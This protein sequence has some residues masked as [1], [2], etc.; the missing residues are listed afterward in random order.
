MLPASPST[1]A[2]RS[3]IEGVLPTDEDVTACCIDHFGAVARQFSSGMSRTDKINRVLLYCPAAEILAALSAHASDRYAQ[4]EHLLIAQRRADANPYRGI[5]PFHAEH[6]SLF[7]GRAALTEK[8][9]RRFRALL[10][11]TDALRILAVLGPSGSGKSSVTLA[12]LVPMLQ[13][14]AITGSI[15]PR[16]GILTPSNRPLEQLARILMQFVDTARAGLSASRQVDIE[17]LLRDPRVPAEGLRRFAA[18]L[19]DSSV[20]PLIIVVDQ[21]EE[22][23]TQCP[24]QQERD[25]FVATLLHA[26]ADVRRQVAV[27]LTLRSDFLGETQRQHPDLNRGIAAQHELVPA[28][29]P[30]EMR[31]AI[32]EPARRAGC[33]LDAAVVDLLLA[34]AHGNEGSLPLLQFALK[35]IWDGVS[36]GNSPTTTLQ[37]LGGVGGALAEEAQQLYA[38]LTPDDQQVAQRAFVR[39]VQLDDGTRATRRRVVLAELCGRGAT[40]EKVLAVLRPFADERVRLITLS[41]PGPNGPD[42]TAEV[43]HEALFERWRSLRSWIEESREDRRFHDRVAAA[44][45]LWQDANRPDGRLWRFPDLLLLRQFQARRGE[46]LTELQTQFWQ[47]SE[48]KLRS[49]RW[50]RNSV[51][52]V[53]ALMVLFVLASLGSLVILQRKAARNDAAHI[54]ELEETKSR[55]KALHRQRRRQLADEAKVQ[56]IL[57]E[58]QKAETRANYAG[59]LE[60]YEKAERKLDEYALSWPLGYAHGGALG[61]NTYGTQL[62]VD[63]LVRRGDLRTALRIIRRAR[64]RGIQPFAALHRLSQLTP[65]DR[66]QIERSLNAFERTRADIDHLVTQELV[67]PFDQLQR[68]REDLLDRNDTAMSQVEEIVRRLPGSVNTEDWPRQP[69]A[70]EALLVCYPLRRGWVCLC[71]DQA[72]L[73]SNIVDNFDPSIPRDRMAALVL[74]PFHAQIERARKLTVIGYGPLRDLDI[75]LLPFGP[76]AAPLLSQ[77]DVVYSLDVFPDGP[78]APALPAPKPEERSG[79]LLLHS[80]AG[81][82]A[83]ADAA[84]G[85]II[86]SLHEAGYKLRVDE[87][88]R[89]QSPERVRTAIANAWLFHSLAHVTE[90]AAGGGLHALQIEP[91]TAGL[92]VTDILTLPQVPKYVTLFGCDSM[93]SGSVWMDLEGL[94]LAQAFLLRGSQAVLGAVRPVSVN[95]AATI[96]ALFFQEFAKR[97]DPVAALRYVVERA[98]SAPLSPIEQA[99]LRQDLGA[100]RIFVP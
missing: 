96:S 24:D 52:G 48:H 25:L 12:G 94:G 76:N 95:G 64:V 99:A 83:A 4:H 33:P 13:G 5:L 71:A 66:Q 78:S 28:M 77:I 42:L 60:L 26:A 56:Q 89:H 6:A 68:F 84:A 23:Y 2:L 43:T 55:V 17:G 87:V 3:F 67:A 37:I 92:T 49:D 97:S 8:L 21:F 47:A 86:R 98:Q 75:H 82:I 72:E 15:P 39:L 65:A 38:R 9:W 11:T 29:S 7:F 18:D 14:H 54:K 27:L 32:E 63:L 57:N 85:S 45:R 51:L 31:Q 16:M 93:R 46:E 10:A 90:S 79:Y 40:P 22:L 70:D 53:V 34:Q 61:R 91:F 69:Q 62:Y 74:Q 19:P 44:T 35:R 81:N 73:Q 36:E 80:A 88:P 100:F 58:G 41:M 20:H 50:W 30:D 59:A 1:A